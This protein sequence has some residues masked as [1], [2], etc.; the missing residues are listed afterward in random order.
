MLQASDSI[1]LL[2]LQQPRFRSGNSTPKTGPGDLLR[3]DDEMP[4][5]IFEEDSRKSTAERSIEQGFSILHSAEPNILFE[6]PNAAR[7]T[8]LEKL[9]DRTRRIKNTTVWNRL[10]ALVK[11]DFKSQL[12]TAE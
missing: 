8:P 9:C 12:S 4:G 1:D 5:E 6:G 11:N 10:K 3:A 7:G 2:N